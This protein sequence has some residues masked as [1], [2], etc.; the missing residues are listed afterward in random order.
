MLAKGLDLP[1][2]TL[3]GVVLADISLNLPDF[4]AAERTFQLVTQVSGRAG[5]SS[6][7]G[8]VVLQ[9]FSPDHYAIQYASAYDFEGFKTTE[10]EYRKKMRYPPFSRMLKL[11]Y[12]HSNPVVLQKQV[13]LQKEQFLTW[14]EEADLRQTELIGPAPCYYEKRA[15]QYRWQI[16]VRGINPG[17]LLELHP[18]SDWTLGGVTVQVTVDPTTLL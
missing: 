5:R 3:V 2:V 18:P 14:I 6:L 10:L 12:R 16:L 9:T 4:R 17:R 15:G 8:R 1:L 13:M 7:G 11:E